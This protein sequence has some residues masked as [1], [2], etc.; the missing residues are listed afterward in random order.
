MSNKIFSSSVKGD[1]LEIVVERTD[2]YATGE[3]LIR[4]D[5]GARNQMA[6][7][8]LEKHEIRALIW[9]LVDLHENA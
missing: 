3:A 6:E 9:S 2:A 5:D 1:D 7:V 8:I 4:I